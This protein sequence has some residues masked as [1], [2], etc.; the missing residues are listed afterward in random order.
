MSPPYQNIADPINLPQAE[1]L[2][3]KMRSARAAAGGDGF[4]PVSCRPGGDFSG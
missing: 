1:N 3:A 2:P 4:L